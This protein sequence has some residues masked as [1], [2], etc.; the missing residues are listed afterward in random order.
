MV[1]KPIG[2]LMT[3]KYPGAISSVTGWANILYESCNLK[4]RS[5]I[6][7]FSFVSSCSCCAATGLFSITLDNSAPPAPCNFSRMSWWKDLSVVMM[8][9]S[10]ESNAVLWRRTGSS[11]ANQAPECLLWPVPVS[12][13]SWTS[14]L[15]SFR[16]HGPSRQAHSLQN[17]VRL[18][19]WPILPPVRGTRVLG[20]LKQTATRNFV[21]SFSCLCDKVCSEFCDHG[22]NS[23][24]DVQCGGRWLRAITIS[25]ND[26]SLTI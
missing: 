13:V 26:N 20:R 7:S 14:P 4:L 3:S 25:I 10:F 18:A 17:Q 2:C 23:I 22:I 11:F 19:F 8:L 9:A 21:L 12:F 24:L 1:D 5:T 16:V 15:S 6:P